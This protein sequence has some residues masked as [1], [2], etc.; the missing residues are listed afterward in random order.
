[1]VGK[2]NGLKQSPSSSM[3][4]NSH[5]ITSSASFNK[6]YYSTDGYDDYLA[7]FRKEGQ[8]TVL[9]LIKAIDPDPGW[10]F[11]DISCGMGGVI[12]ALR[13]LGFKSWGTEISPYCLKHSP[14]K[15]WIKSENVC[16]LSYE[17][18]SFDVV[19]CMDVFCYLNKEEALQA[20]KELVRIAKH[21]LYIESVC[22]GS[23]NSSQ[24]SNPDLLRKDEDLLTAGE[25]KRMFENNK[26]LFLK[27]LYPKNESQDFSGIFVK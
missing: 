5:Q 1:M 22:R 3:R 23:S 7:K 8:Q 14:A 25:I 10:H 9:R 13:K 26:T 15:K 12:L 18:S 17:D 4:K 6:A 19:I 20:S 2:K 24:R 11:L 16:Q 27:P 21:Y